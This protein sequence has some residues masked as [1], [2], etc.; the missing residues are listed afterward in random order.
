[1]CLKIT[2]KINLRQS[3]ATSLKSTT[4]YS[5][6]KIKPFSIKQQQSDYLYFLSYDKTI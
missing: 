1:M 6:D 3:L 2:T 5:R 4:L